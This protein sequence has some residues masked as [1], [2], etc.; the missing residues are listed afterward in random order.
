MNIID[1]ITINR[2]HDDR[3]KEF[4]VGTVEALGW[5]D[6]ESQ[7][8]RFEVLSKIENLDGLTLMDAGCG[9]GDLYPFL[10]AKYPAINYVGIDNNAAL[11]DIAIERYGN[12][13]QA[14]FLLGD[15]TTADLDEVDYI[16]CSGALS[17]SNRDPDFIKNIIT[18]LFT[19]CKLGLGFNLLNK[20]KN[21]GGIL[22]AYDPA[23]IMD[24]CRH[25][26]DSVQIRQ[27]Y[28]PDDFTV[29][30]YKP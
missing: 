3:G 14:K 30:L 8:I 18:K 29:F 17:Y 28:L 19:A 16:L 5:P 23:E 1:R 9:H 2:F 12:D 4:G 6:S 13:K 25:L 15:F 7:R 26:T 10:L 24:S 22:V 20:V 11:L 27:N 21:P